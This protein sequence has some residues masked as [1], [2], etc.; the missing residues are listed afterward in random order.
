MIKSMY[1]L[2]KEYHS[3]AYVPAIILFIR[4]LPKPKCFYD[5]NMSVFDIIMY[6]KGWIKEFLSLSLYMWHVWCCLRGLVNYM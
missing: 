2:C 6:F 1:Y 3:V 5:L 4:C